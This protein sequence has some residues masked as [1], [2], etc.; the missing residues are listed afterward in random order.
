MAAGQPTSKPYVVNLEAVR[1]EPQ[2][3][4][5]LADGAHLGLVDGREPGQ[6]SGDD[7]IDVPAIT[8]PVRRWSV[9]SSLAGRDVARADLASGQSLS[10][11]RDAL[12]VVVRANRDIGAD[13]QGRVEYLTERPPVG[14]PGQDQ[15]AVARRLRPP[16]GN[17]EAGTLPVEPLVEHPH[18]RV[19]ED[20]AVPQPGHVGVA[21]AQPP[22]LAHRQMTGTPPMLQQVGAQLRAEPPTPPATYRAGPRSR[23]CRRLAPQAPA[24]S[25]TPAGR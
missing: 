17:G 3:A 6:H 11:G 24:P 10:I 12:A 21:G 5:V 25:P 2:G 16:G 7:L 23:A 9:A 22:Q 8:A 14:V 18:N 1:R 13:E 19:V 20:G 15:T 4:R